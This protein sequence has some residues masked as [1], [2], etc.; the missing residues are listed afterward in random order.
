M[1]TA[2]PQEVAFSVIYAAGTL[3]CGALSSSVGGMI[4]DRWAK[5]HAGAHGFLPA[6]GA[7]LSIFPTA[8]MFYVPSF[9]ASICCLLVV[10]LLSECWLGPCMGL[11]I[12]DVPPHMT[13]TQVALLLVCDR[14]GTEEN[15]QTNGC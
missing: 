7:A 15:T 8:A 14:R 3:V 13:G 6:V 5:R 10:I 4:A 11:L 12:K 9:P 1:F 2:T